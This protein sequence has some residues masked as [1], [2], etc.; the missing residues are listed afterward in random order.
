MTADAT[1]ESA[2]NSLKSTSKQALHEFGEVLEEW[3]A[4]LGGLLLGWVLGTR[5]GGQSGVA[6]A[7]APVI[8][9]NNDS[10]MWVTEHII[11]G[12]VMFAAFGGI[13][14]GLLTAGHSMKGMVGKIVL[15]LFGG[16]LVG[17]GLLNLVWGVTGNGTVT[18]FD[19][20]IIGIGSK[21]AALVPG[22]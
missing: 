21:A 1:G 4:P 14:L 17:I 19:N 7:F 6:A 15:K 20:F 9:P 11:G 22:G 5:I 12:I 16:T 8:N 2:L 13:G 3:L 10:S 18:P